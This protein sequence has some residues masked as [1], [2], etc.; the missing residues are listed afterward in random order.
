MSRQ[1]TR[2]PSFTP[3]LS[4]VML[5]RSGSFR[6]S[7]S[8]DGCASRN[9]IIGIRLCPPA[10]GFASPSWEASS[11]TASFK[12]EGQ[13]YSNGGNF[14]G[15]LSPAL[16]KA[17][18]ARGGQYAMLRRYVW[19][20]RMPL[21]L[22]MSVCNYDRTAALFD[23]RARIE[24]CCVAAVPLVPEESFH[25]AFKYQEFD[26]TE[27]SMSS[28]LLT[29]ARG[30]AHYVAIPAFVSRL[31][32]HSGIYIRTD[33]GIKKPEDLKGKTI[34]LPEYQMTANVWVRGMLLEEYGV[35][36]SDI[37]WRNGG[38]EE[39]GRAE[40]TKITLPKEIELQSIPKDRTL[41]DMLAKG[42]IDGLFSARAPSCF[43]AGAPNVGRLFPNYPEVE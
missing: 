14:M 7:T 3:S 5:L 31:F 24:G 2:A 25:R 11:A 36:P 17:V 8:S 42:E 19:R 38:L 26:I 27:V 21:S 13:A 9:A 28:Y 23:G 37:K 30:D 18:N 35:K 22:S 1:R 40:R 33:R 43:V 6:R 15:Q 4:I 20:T 32:R 34:G 29:T 12:V 16:A 41:N 39:A 10:I